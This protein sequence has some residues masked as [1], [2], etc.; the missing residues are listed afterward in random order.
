MNSKNDYVNDFAILLTINL[1]PLKPF[2]FI[3]LPTA[4]IFILFI[5]VTL[6]CSYYRQYL[7]V[8]KYKN[9]RILVSDRLFQ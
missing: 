7:F 5:S 6:L 9:S 3:S 8:T 2:S 4:A 1:L